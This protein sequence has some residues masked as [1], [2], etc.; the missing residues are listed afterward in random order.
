MTNDQSPKKKF[1]L[2]D[3]TLD[4]AK[5]VVRMCKELP[6]NTVND[7]LV[8]QVIRSAGSVGANY[9]EANDALGTKDFLMRLKISRKEV[10]ETHFWL[11]LIIEANPDLKK[12]IE[13]LFQE[14]LELKKI[15]S[16]IITKLQNK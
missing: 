9:R 12:R 8:D 1:D 4:F 10:K 3:R 14:S 15:L 11:E 7:N 16:A 5:R 13:S 2:E 6:T